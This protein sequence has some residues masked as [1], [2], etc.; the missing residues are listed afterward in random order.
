[1]NDEELN[2]WIRSHHESSR[3]EC[4]VCTTDRRKSNKRDMQITV[5]GDKILYQCWHCG[6]SGRCSKD[7]APVHKAAVTPISLPKT[8]DSDLIAEYLLSRGASWGTLIIHQRLFVS[9]ALF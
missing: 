5:E 1:M 3:V 7:K 8:S 9:T 6:I 4:P 2:G